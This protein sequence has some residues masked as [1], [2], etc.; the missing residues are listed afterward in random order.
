MSA[1]QNLIDAIRQ[2]QPS[3]RAGAACD[4]SGVVRKWTQMQADRSLVIFCL[5]DRDGSDHFANLEDVCERIADD[6][7]TVGRGAAR[8]AA[9]D[10]AKMLAQDPALDVRTVADQTD[11]AL[12]GPVPDT[13]LF[14]PVHGVGLAAPF[15]GCGIALRAFEPRALAGE[16]A[17]AGHEDFMANHLEED[18]NS[19]R[20]Y[21]IARLPTDDERGF[22]IVRS[23]T[24]VALVLAMLSYAPPEQHWWDEFSATLTPL[25]IH[26]MRT[27]TSAGATT[28][29]ERSL[30]GLPLQFDSARVAAALGV[31]P[32]MS[33]LARLAQQ[34]RRAR[35]PI[36]GRILRA[37]TLLAESL[38]GQPEDRFLRR[39]MALEALVGRE[40][41]EVTERLSERLA[42]LTCDDPAE[43]IRRKGFFRKLYGWRSDIAHGRP[44]P[45]LKRTSE[46]FKV[47]SFGALERRRTAADRRRRC[48][49]G[50]HADVGDRAPGCDALE[51]PW[52]GPARGPQPERSEPDLAGL[53]AGPASGRALRAVQ[54]SAVHREGPGHH[55]PVP[56][57][58]GTGPGAVRR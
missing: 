46:I 23:R 43:R 4:G 45:L 55:W 13:T 27:F 35:T 42:V 20:V 41:G 47:L 21:S 15:D 44:L 8:D 52:D 3:V 48:G 12:T 29:P 57:S 5:V 32:A 2:I 58:A 40:P 24:Q 49:A 36:Q 38:D 26:S 34:P 11:A 56:E 53:R 17:F 16:F 54:G 18:R 10:V 28:S 50:A 31:R 6:A 9:R 14:Q 51:H 30:Y 22:L 33:A 19:V 7:E 39:W 25:G 1:P 37:A